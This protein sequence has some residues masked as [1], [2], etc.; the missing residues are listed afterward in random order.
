M[1]KGPFHILLVEDNKLHQIVISQ[2]MRKHGHTVAIA[3]DGKE[4]VALL[5]KQCFDLILM[6]I[7]MPGMN[8][9]EATRTIRSPDSKVFDHN[10]PIIAVTSFNGEDIRKNCFDAGMD[11]FIPKPLLTITA[12][13][14]ALNKITRLSERNETKTGINNR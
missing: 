2:L 14:K 5:E 9:I 4:A 11:A 8:G 12:L 3:N 7:Q 1:N 6:D 10:V 13:H